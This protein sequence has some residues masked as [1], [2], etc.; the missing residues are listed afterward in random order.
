M[1][2]V[3]VVV[4]LIAI[5]PRPTRAQDDT[6][7]LLRCGV[8][9]VRSL[10]SGDADSFHIRQPGDRVL[11][12]AIDISGDIGL[13]KLVVADSPDLTTC[14]GTLALDQGVAEIEVSDCIANPSDDREG[15]YTIAMSVVSQSPG[16]CGIPLP[17]DTAVPGRLAVRGEVDSYVFPASG[18]GSEVKVALGN[19]MPDSQTYRMRVFD[20][21]GMPV[22]GGDSCDGIIS[23]APNQPGLYTVLVSACAKPVTGHYLISW[24]PTTCP[25]GLDIGTV[26]GAAGQTV[27]F[28]VALHTYGNPI[29]ATQSEI[30][31]DPNTPIAARRRGTPDCA[32]NPDINKNATAF[33]F[34]PDG[35]SGTGCSSVRAIVFAT[36]NSDPIDDGAILFTCNVSVAAAAAPGSYMLRCDDALASTPTGDRLFAACSG[37]QIIVGA[38]VCPGDCDGNGQVTVDELVK[39]V[40]VALGLADPLTC[41]ALDTDHDGRVSVSELVAAVNSSL[42]GCNEGAPAAAATRPRRRTGS[43]SS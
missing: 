34:L 19:V 40:N 7:D 35:C 17:C 9:M 20:P 5:V 15:Q 33:A 21:D 29:A 26:N 22:D 37:G 12:D 11:I 23:I 6:G 39:G 13:L 16:N 38:M 2:R 32:V 24:T 42:A 1:I 41:T 36:D 8:P 3:I 28:G 25:V 31:F 14:S 27:Q 4:A 30:L 10:E 18:D 43:E